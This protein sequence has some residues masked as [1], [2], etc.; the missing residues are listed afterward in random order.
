MNYTVVWMPR[1]QTQLAAVWTAATNQKAV[2]EATY[3]I[4]R[5]LADDPLDTGESRDANRRLAFDPPLQV[6]F[7]VFAGDKRV[8]KVSVGAFGRG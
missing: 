7:R 5:S 6:M 2:T 3:R 1:A 4:E 8:E